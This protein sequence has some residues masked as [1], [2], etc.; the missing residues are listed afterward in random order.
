MT[1]PKEVKEIA[2]KLT[3]A[4][5]EAYLV[6]GCLRD[7][8][9]SEVE[10]RPIIPKD[11]DLTTNATPKEIQKLFP[12]SV[13]ENRFG[14]VG[15]KIPTPEG[16]GTPAD[17]VG[18]GK[19]IVEVTTFRIDGSYTDKRHPDVV[20]FAKTVE[21]DL[22]RRDFTVNAMAMGLT[23]KIVD[24]HGGQEDLKNK[25]IR[26]V[27]DPV[28]RFQEDALRLVRAVRFSAQLGF[29]IEKKTL[30]ALAKEHGLIEFVAK[31]RIRDEFEKLLMT[32]NAH[33]GV[34]ELQRGGLLKIMIPEL[35]EGVGM[36]Q[37]LHHIYTVFE[38]N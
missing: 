17:S 6:G 34:R 30:E 10:G 13:Y 22:S 26:A 19:M 33:E 25:I 29:V 18:A 8:I 28:K 11:W 24:P 37:N 31:E 36:E 38:H 27:G 23:G 32:D 35:E 21:D 9:L 12:D 2:N 1:I 20:K 7:L 5:F 4:G 15:V 16:V 3:K 14:T